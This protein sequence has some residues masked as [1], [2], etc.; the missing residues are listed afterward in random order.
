MRDEIVDVLSWAAVFDHALNSSDVR[1]YLT[2]ECSLDEVESVLTS[3][4][5]VERTGGRWHISGSGYDSHKFGKMSNSATS[6]LNGGLPIISKLCESDQVLALAITG[7]V[8]SGSSPDKADV[9]I[10]IITRPNYVWRVRA[11]AIFLEHNSPGSS[12]ICPNMVL[13][14][15]YLTLRPSTYAA[16]ELAMMRPVKG[17]DVFEKM[18]SENP[19]FKKTLPNAALSS[20]IELPEAKG[21]FPSWWRAMR[22]PIIGKIIERWEAGRRIS[23]CSKDSTST[24]SVYEIYRCIGHESAHRTRI[25]E[26]MAEI[27][28]E[29]TTV[30]SEVQ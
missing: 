9:D 30:E 25:E 4:N 6:Q 27:T 5:Q 20:S 15:R 11:L 29:V 10:L 21:E 19:W 18:L 7:S 24:E 14:Y 2:K 8:A 3:I 23:Q 1:R 22:I 12:I 26:R 13:D 17:R 28:R 16:R